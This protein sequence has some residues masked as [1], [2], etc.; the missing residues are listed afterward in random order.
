MLFWSN[1]KTK[2]TLLITVLMMCTGIFCSNVFAR[3]K[4]DNAAIYCR[5]QGLFNN[6]D[7]AEEEFKMLMEPPKH[8]NFREMFSALRYVVECSEENKKC[9]KALKNPECGISVYTQQ[10]VSFYEENIVD[11]E[12]KS[13]DKF[14]L[15][16]TK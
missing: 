16:Q 2:L 12:G 9:A 15:L 7:N 5:Y 8:A 10:L 1:M 14:S 11:I 6:V 3:F 4:C 13:N